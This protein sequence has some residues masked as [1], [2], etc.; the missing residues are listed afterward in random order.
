MPGTDEMIL[1]QRDGGPPTTLA[2]GSAP[3]ESGVSV[4]SMRFRGG[5]HFSATTRQHLVWFHS[6]MQ[7]AF[8][9]RIAG[10][11]LRHQPTAGSLAIRPA[12][13]DAAADAEA[14]VDAM[15]VMI[16]PNHFV[17]AAA[18]DSALGAMLIE[19]LSGYDQELLDLCRELA[20]ESAGHYPSGP[21]YWNEVASKFIFALVARHTSG[22]VRPPRGSLGKNVLD[23]LRDY[24]L[25]HLDEPIEVSTLADIAGA[26]RSTSLVCSSGAS[27][28]RPTAI[29]CICACVAPSS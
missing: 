28:S 26:A 8:H 19:R 13:V 14:S 7:T 11:A 10:R 22:P 17:L 12:G 18:E 15:V 23:R 29:S 27:A 24:V 25:S 9:C 1:A 4:L 2:A 3:G 16:D 5:A 6:S 20:V 21:L